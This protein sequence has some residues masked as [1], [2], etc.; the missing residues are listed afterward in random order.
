MSSS[1]IYS[2]TMIAMLFLVI[3]SM[4]RLFAKAGEA[5]WK[6]VVP[7]YNV[8]VLF[9]L[10]GRPWWWLVLMLVPVVNLIPG[11]M[12]CFDLAKAYGKG[13]GAGFGILLLGPIFIMWLAFG[14]ARYVGPNRT[15]P[16]AMRHAA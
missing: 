6:S 2:V 8:V 14:D 3:A 15:A 13:T 16:P 12:V 1:T 4:W 11:I 5:G 9:K 10:V 7:I